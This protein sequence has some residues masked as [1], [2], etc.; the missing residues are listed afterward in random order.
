VFD[1]VQTCW[2]PGLANPIG[3]CPLALH[4]VYQASHV[5]VEFSAD[6]I[7][8]FAQFLQVQSTLYDCAQGVVFACGDASARSKKLLKNLAQLLAIQG[9][10]VNEC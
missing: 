3:I 8:L 1:S 10:Q 9:L 2:Q 7:P 6:G 4:E 5:L